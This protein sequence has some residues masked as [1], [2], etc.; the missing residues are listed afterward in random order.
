MASKHAETQVR[1]TAD[2]KQFNSKVKE[3]K[4]NFQDFAK[5]SDQVSSKLSDALG[6]PTDKINQMAGA[7]RGLGQKLEQT[8][9][10]GAQAFAGILKNV[11]A[12]STAI[13]GIGIGAAVSAFKLLNAEA[14]AFKNTIQ[15]A[16]IDAAT[17]TYIDTYRQSMRDAREELGA[18]T[19][20][21]MAEAKK[22]L[23]TMATDFISILAFGLSNLFKGNVTPGMFFTGGAAMTAAI[24][25]A[26]AAPAAGEAEKYANQLYEVERKISDEQQVQAAL[27]AAI[28]KNK[29][30]A[31]DKSRSTKE[32]MES[33]LEVERLIK[34]QYEGG[35]EFSYLDVD[36][37]VVT[38]TVSGLRTLYNER[39]T[40][41]RAINAQS[42]SSVEAV[43]AENA[44]VAQ[45]LQVT[46]G[47][48]N[49]LR[50]LLERKTS[51]NTS[52]TAAAAA[53]QKE[54]DA[55]DALKASYEG[56]KSLDLSTSDIKLPTT[57]S[58]PAT[59]IGAETLTRSFGP[60]AWEEFAKSVDEGFIKTFGDLKIGIGVELDK[61]QVMNFTTQLNSL[62]SSSVESIG[63]TIG[64]L[65]GD[66][67]T[68]G[69][70]WEN[71]RNSAV[72]AFGDMAIA[73]GK[74]A[75]EA[76]I[77]TLGLKA[78]FESLNPYVAM[79]AGA[80]LIALGTAVKA[81]LSNV[82]S[83][84][85]SSSS[86]TASVASSSYSSS[87]SSQDWAQSEVNVKVTGTLQANGS[88]LVAVLNNEEK[89]KSHTT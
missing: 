20:T 72:S 17:Q 86:A 83:G 75:V 43:N 6:I 50:E 4:Q 14:T 26:Q 34:L 82:A 64:Q 24:K 61:E 18:G 68:G 55:V 80:A 76:G 84:N 46:Q 79:A 62:I 70:A 63:S 44:A 77:A 38:K 40:L 53:A 9:S 58:N 3:S 41:M 78:A 22:G 16:N 66:L 42:S 30:E 73:V 57:L 89:R 8:G 23:A 33:L 10:T 11:G 35:G 2:T 69:D 47:W 51:I 88:A 65:L 87:S 28:A 5:V 31:Y 19:A 1:V 48:D 36:G 81:G 52:M 15:G 13:A 32:Q 12:A 25:Q 21:A 39:A 71:F 27:T 29:L 45:A 67:A 60:T 49:A 74:I 56:M 37:K 54:K 85:Y 7:L 59:D